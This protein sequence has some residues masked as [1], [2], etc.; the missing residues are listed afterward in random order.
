MRS[1]IIAVFSALALLASAQNNI[2]TLDLSNTEIPLEFDSENGAW[3]GTY[4][5]D[6]YTIDSQIYTFLHNSMGDYNT[7]WGFTVSN[8]ADNSKREDFLT[9]QFS[10]MAKGGIVLDENGSVKLDE[11]GA[12]V[13]SPSIPYLVAFANSYFAQ[14][15]AE[16]VMSDGEDHEAVGVYVCLNSYTFYSVS[17]GDGF[18]RAFNNGDKYTL[19]IHGVNSRD[20]EKSIDVQLAAYANGDLT[21]TRGWTYVDLSELG[22]VNTIWFSVKSTDSGAYGDNTPS[23]FCLD[24]LMVKPVKST[25]G[26]ESE[27]VSKGAKISYDKADAMVRLVNA[28]F[29]IVYDVAGNKVMSVEASEFSVAS[30]DHG[31]YV[32]RAGNASRK[33]AR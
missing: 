33:I 9:Y 14:H 16:V 18:A 28:D 32:V 8:S 6:E 25:T 13:V 10:N 3:T 19:T 23:Y 20:E 31:I 17:D 27:A 2:I 29:A 26:A 22:E 12:P 21:T 4:N 15:P 5:D 11:F 24:K 7:W 30:L 1:F